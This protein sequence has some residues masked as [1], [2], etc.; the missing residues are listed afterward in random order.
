MNAPFYCTLGPK[1]TFFWQLLHAK[2]VI[3]VYCRLYFISPLAEKDVTSLL[4]SLHE[5]CRKHKKNTVVSLQTSDFPNQ[6]TNNGKEQSD[7]REGMN[8]NKVKSMATQL[9]AKFEENAS[10]TILRRQVGHR[11]T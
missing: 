2:H 5:C 7:G 6:G 8:Q 3:S 9:L 1:K 10:N 11:W 4:L